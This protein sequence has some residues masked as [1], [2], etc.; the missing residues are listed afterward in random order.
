MKGRNNIWLCTMILMIMFSGLMLEQ[1]LAQEIQDDTTEN[2]F[3]PEELPNE[4]TESSEKMEKGSLNEKILNNVQNELYDYW[5]DHAE[6]LSGPDTLEGGIGYQMIMRLS[7]F[8]NRTFFVIAPLAILIG[9]AM[10]ILAGMNKPLKKTGLLIMFGV[11][12]VLALLA[13]GV[14]ISASI[15]YYGP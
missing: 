5:E 15:H 8:C 4:Q 9:L 3:V 12:I 14:P 7:I 2:V 10:R 6:Q 1:V 13:Y 11:P